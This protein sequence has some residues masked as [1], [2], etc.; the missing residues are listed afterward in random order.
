MKPVPGATIGAAPQLRDLKAEAVA[1]VPTIIKRRKAPVVIGAGTLSAINA[2][3]EQAREEGEDKVERVSLLSAL[4]SNGIVGETALPS[5]N[6][7]KEDYD[8][9]LSD[10]GDLL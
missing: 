1:F 8:R 5:R 9:F 10:M 6:K 7:G 2:A 3:P 4:K